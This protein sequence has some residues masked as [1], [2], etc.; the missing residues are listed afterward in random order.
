MEL[1]QL[2]VLAL[3]VSIVCTVFGFGLR[4]T[5]EDLLYLVRRPGLLLR[6]LIA[7]FLIMPL[8]AIGLDLMFH[9]RP[10]LEIVLVALAFSPVPPI[11]PQKE[12]KMGGSA[13]YGLGLMA[14]LSI[15]S[16]VAV[17]MSVTLLGWFL[18]RPFAMAPGAI[19]RIALTAAILPLVAG[20]AV[21]ALAPGIADRIKG[22]VDLAARVL[23]P[24]S[25]LVL[26]AASW[27]AI[28]AAV[29]DGTIY[30]MV[31]FVGLGLIVGHLM[32]G[33]DPEHSIVLALSTACRHPAIALSIAAANFPNERFAGTILL[34]LIVSAIVGIPYIAWQRRQMVGTVSPASGARVQRRRV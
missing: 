21:R 18:G 2:V 20:A 28:W 17:P 14:I 33:P 13:S 15:V 7:V 16:I 5:F 32:G 4:T 34:Y 31:A 26:L 3:K 27:Q 8:L 9:F 25:A 12:T 1:K 6:S 29:G 11:L 10:T 30:A 24:L 23:L 22:P 19:A